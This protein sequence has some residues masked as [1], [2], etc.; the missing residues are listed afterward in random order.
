M[1][2]F[3]LMLVAIMAMIGVNAMAVDTDVILDGFDQ[4]D[5]VSVTKDYT[6]SPFHLKYTVTNLVFEGTTVKKATV[7]V[8]K[9]A[10]LGTTASITIPEKI[11][12]VVKINNT[13]DADL[14]I[15]QAVEF[16]VTSIE[17]DAF[18]GTSLTS[19]TL[20]AKLEEI[21]DNAFEDLE[22]ETISL[23][24]TLKAIGDEAFK[25]TAIES[26]SI[27]AS[28]E[29][30]GAGAFEN[31]AT[32]NAFTLAASS[33]LHTIGAGAFAYTSL[34]ELNL[35]TATAYDSD[36]NAATPAEGMEVIGAIF[37]SAATTQNG[38]IRT[39]VLPTTC[40]EVD[41]EAFKNCKKLATI[42][43]ENVKEIGDNAF[44]N[45]AKLATVAIGT[46]ATFEDGYA[47][48][49]GDDAFKGCTSLTTV[50]FGKI[51]GN[52]IAASPNA[53][54]VSGSI[55]TLTFNEI[56]GAIT[57]LNLA[58]ITSITFNE[59]IT[60]A[61]YVP[62]STFTNAFVEGGTVT[63]NVTIP[64]GVLVPALNMN[65]AAFSADGDAVRTI[66]MTVS[67]AIKDEL[68]SATVLNKVLISGD[69]SVDGNVYIG[70]GT[71]DEAKKLIKDKN[72]SN[73]YYYF[74]GDAGSNYKIAR[75]NEG[76]AKVSVYQVYV[77]GD[78]SKIYYQPMVSKDGYFY[79]EPQVP[80]IIKSNKENR[81]VAVPVTTSDDNNTMVYSKGGDVVNDL[82][83][84]ATKMGLVDIASTPAFDDKDI[85]FF[86]NPATAGFGFSLFDPSVN[87][88]LKGVYFLV[89]AAAGARIMENVWL[90]E[91]GNVTAIDK[92]QITPA[93]DDAIYNMAGQNVSASYKGVVIKNG[94]KYIQ[95]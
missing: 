17:D 27:P 59:Y 25:G 40:Y 8:T 74:Y 4:G 73:Y 60:D 79:V 37:T 6:P 76:D 71:T 39:V 51:D 2:K 35:S 65:V 89:N 81:V 22:I 54:F 24:S 72:S 23:P 70:N 26:I 87:K 30:I 55:T 94:K 93:N 1:K 82:E 78:A 45:C 68:A 85:Y 80:V 90:D 9:G 91:D 66:T 28:V 48:V 38:I 95:K 50:E 42:N 41:D 36:G 31:C 62:A 49:I 64:S 5:Y 46:N 15:D 61:T 32:L 16:T 44:E 69:W 77:D 13:A 14:N 34:T 19:V 43:L 10:E 83:Y 92:V 88:T 75:V 21:G 63:Y 7:S 57:N 84:S 20:P 67:K 11:E 47:L 52:S 12:F 86:A 18:T 53:S 33:N 3:K 58:S 29:T 56:A